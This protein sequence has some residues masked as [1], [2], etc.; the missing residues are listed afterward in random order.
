MAPFCEGFLATV[1][2][3][4]LLRSLVTP[5]Q[6]EQI[7]CGVE[8]PMDTSAVKLSSKPNGWSAE[9]TSYLEDFWAVIDSSR[10]YPLTETLPYPRRVL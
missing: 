2:H 9:D 5:S 4:K 7:I 10:T 8:Q 1:G 3:S 6:L